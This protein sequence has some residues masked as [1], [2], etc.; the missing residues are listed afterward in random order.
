MKYDAKSFVSHPN[1]FTPIGCSR[2]V[3]DPNKLV[4]TPTRPAISRTQGERYANCV[5]FS[6]YN[7]FI[8]R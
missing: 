5:R 1:V 8:E 4:F 2:E 7:K 3:R 6:T